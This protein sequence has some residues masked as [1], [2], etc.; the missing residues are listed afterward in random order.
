[1]KKI[2]KALVTGLL[3]AMVVAIG[4]VFYAANFSPGAPGGAVTPLVEGWTADGVPV[5][6]PYV[7]EQHDVTLTRALDQVGPDT[8]LFLRTNYHQVTATLDGRALVV[9]GR[10]DYG[11]FGVSYTNPWV[12]IKIP[13][14]GVLSLRVSDQNALVVGTVTLGA[15]ADLLRALIRDNAGTI[16]LCVFL[17][18]LGLITIALAVP[19]GRRMQEMNSTGFFALGA[20][21]LF[22]AIWILTDSNLLRIFC[23]NTDALYFTSY[24]SF[25]LLPVPLA[26]FIRQACSKYRLVLDV[27]A[28]VFLLWFGFVVTMLV[29]RVHTLMYFLPVTHILLIGTALCLCVVCA[30]DRFKNKNHALT[31]ILFGITAL[32]VCSALALA[33]YY[34]LP[35]VDNAL[36]FRQGVL[37]FTIF[38][39]V[40]AVRRTLLVLGE[41]QSFTKLAGNIPCGLV[42][43]TAD[44]A[45][46]IR[47]ANDFYYEM[48]G[49]DPEAP[50][51]TTLGELLRPEDRVALINRC[52]SGDMR[53]EQ[54]LRQ[55]TASGNEIWV[56][57]CVNHNPGEH[58][59]TIAVF[60]ITTRKQVE[61]QLRI[62]EEEYRIA[63]E[64]SDKL[65]LRHDIRTH[66]S[67]YQNRA[68]QEFGMPDVMDNV[69]E[70][71]LKRGIIAPES[72]TEYCAMYDAMHAGAPEGSANIRIKTDRGW[73]WYHADFTTIFDQDGAP[74]QAVLSFYDIT[75]RREREIAYEKWRQSYEALP[76]ESMQYYE[77]NLS[78]DTFDH[79]EGALLPGIPDDVPRT[80]TEVILYTATYFVFA[81]DRESFSDFYTRERLLARF[82]RGMRSDTMEFRRIEA[83]EP[84]WTRAAVQLLADPYSCLR[85]STRW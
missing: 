40:S 36:F 42:R 77:C 58:E 43:V 9:D 57:I 47:Y 48:F 53:F 59:L 78:R 41:S 35:R 21:S 64:Q 18:L 66:R 12:I 49:Y 70:S 16:L 75:D 15:E 76:Q 6:L 24:F 5:T 38:L 60:D 51:I 84:R 74:L 22:A 52:F 72:E 20:F 2:Q 69:P 56:L 65:I 34:L 11:T 28:A 19:I 54:E 85:T 30:V 7:T 8:A 44:P 81:E 55:I 13:H 62:R 4:L 73:R 63:A 83:G 32:T 27:L 67:Q 46:T 61:E 45:F 14:A 1:M 82:D 10:H 39:I 29:A 25:M 26:L 80:L 23:S 79:E 37:L 71:V 33:R 31:E 50:G 68:S 3:C 17:V